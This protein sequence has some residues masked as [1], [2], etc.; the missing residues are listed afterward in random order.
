MNDLLMRGYR[1]AKEGELRWD[2]CP[3]IGYSLVTEGTIKVKSLLLADGVEDSDQLFKHIGR[4]GIYPITGFKYPYQGVEDFKNAFARLVGEFYD[5]EEILELIGEDAR[6]YNCVT[7]IVIVDRGLL[8]Q[9]SNSADTLIKPRP[10]FV[11]S[12][13][14]GMVQYSDPWLGE[15]SNP[16]IM[17]SSED[18]S[19]DGI[20]IISEDLFHTCTPLGTELVIVVVDDTSKFAGDCVTLAFVDNYESA[21]ELASNVSK[22]DHTINSINVIGEQEL[23]EKALLEHT[24]CIIYTVPEKSYLD[25]TFNMDKLNIGHLKTLI[26]NTKSDDVNGISFKEYKLEKDR[27]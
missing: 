24:E 20:Y 14:V 7:S 25:K 11:V 3:D 5:L 19:S 1:K 4:S 18:N 2:V 17:I 12:G 27:G 23:I 10:I 26:K 15:L 13:D 9:I 16:E 22:T 6:F 21:V 8:L